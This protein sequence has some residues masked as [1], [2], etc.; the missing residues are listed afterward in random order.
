ME[1]Y[2]LHTNRFNSYNSHV[3]QIIVG[4]GF[5]LVAL[6][7]AYLDSARHLRRCCDKFLYFFSCLLQKPIALPLLLNNEIFFKPKQYRNVS[8]ISDSTSDSEFTSEGSDDMS[9]FVLAVQEAN[10]L[11]S[12]TMSGF[13]GTTTVCNLLVDANFKPFAL[14]LLAVS[15][16]YSLFGLY[17]S[18]YMYGRK[19]EH[20]RI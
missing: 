17:I 8:S 6:L 4:G 18:F 16:V 2:Y 11:Y 5:Q 10:F 14:S 15:F 3:I 13:I 20:Q 19:V 1:T 9:S 12:F 7:A